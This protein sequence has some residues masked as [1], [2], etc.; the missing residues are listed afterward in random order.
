MNHQISLSLLLL[1]TVA[2]TSAAQS[3]GQ[4]PK[5]IMS[6]VV[7][8]YQGE[9]SVSSMSLITCTYEIQ[10]GR[11]RCESGKRKKSLQSFVKNYG[12]S[13]KDTKG[14]THILSPV[15]EKGISILQYD[16]EDGNK[17]TDQWLYLPL[18]QKVKRI[19]SDGSAPKK[20]S[21]FGSEFSMEDIERLKVDEYTYE[22][23]E[24]KRIRDMNV[25]VLDI[26][27]SKARA[28]RTNYSRQK[29]WVDTDRNLVVKVEYYAWDG[30]LMKV[31][32]ASDIKEVDG[33]W[34]VGR[35]VMRNVETRRISELS[36]KQV[37]YNVDIPDEMLTQRVLTDPAFRASV[38]DSAMV[39]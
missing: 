3:K 35:E 16:Y 37:N 1:C 10:N 17:D 32:Q 24:Q 23:V 7:D 11:V 6:A 15:S 33:I 21:L 30:S 25:A 5:Q 39:E 19:A 31:R 14:F 9:S 38:L 18:L 12:A 29:V 13:L 22:L 36:Y 28:A 8:R 2:W 20:G 34:T 26:T 27:P 4:D